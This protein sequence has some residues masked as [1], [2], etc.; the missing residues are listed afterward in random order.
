MAAS[1]DYRI[2]NAI[3]YFV[4]K[5]A[6]I[7]LEM[8]WAIL[9]RSLFFASFAVILYLL[10]FFTPSELNHIRKLLKLNKKD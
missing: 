1:L 7:S 8:K 9:V 6:T 4:A 2:L 10:K 5:E 3:V